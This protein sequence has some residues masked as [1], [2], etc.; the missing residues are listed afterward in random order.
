MFHKILIL[1][2]GATLSSAAF[3][4]DFGLAIGIHETAASVDTTSSGVMT[5]STS[6]R[7]NFDVGVLGSFEMVKN[8]HFR[9]GVLYDERKFDF[10]VP[11]PQAGSGTYTFN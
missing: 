10:K 6:G 8:L 11:A 5:G 1:L 9:T 2:F 3:A 4:Q 7:L